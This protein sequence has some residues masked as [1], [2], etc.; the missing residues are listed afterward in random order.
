MIV[1]L[2]KIFGRDSMPLSDEHFA[3]ICLALIVALVFIGLAT[4]TFR[5]NKRR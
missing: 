2:F 4:S 5:R 1:T 3:D